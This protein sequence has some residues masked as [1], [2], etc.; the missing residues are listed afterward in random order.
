MD[1]EDE[2]TAIPTIKMMYKDAI[3]PSRQHFKMRYCILLENTVVD[4]NKEKVW[5]SEFIYR[6]FDIQ[7]IKNVD[8]AAS[9]AHCGF[10]WKSGNVV[11][12]AK[13][14]GKDNWDKITS[15]I[16]YFSYSRLFHFE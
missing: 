1:E 6:Q 4:K 10:K 13:Q 14:V 12:S 8:K 7:V 3:D 5:L 2:L 16:W 11:I 9:K 15:R